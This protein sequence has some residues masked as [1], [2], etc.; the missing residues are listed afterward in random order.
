[1]KQTEIKDL[2]IEELNDKISEETQVLS[3]LVFGHTVSKI[4]NPLKIRSTRRGI[5]RLKTELHKR[6]T[7][8]TAN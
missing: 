3:K 8:S 1:M 6:E 7:T 4:E 2:S 5:A